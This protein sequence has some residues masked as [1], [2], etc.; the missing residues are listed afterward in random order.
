MQSQGHVDNSGSVFFLS[1][2]DAVLIGGAEIDVYAF[3]VA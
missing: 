2:E 1:D 3:V